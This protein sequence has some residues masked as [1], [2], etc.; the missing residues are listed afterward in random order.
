MNTYVCSKFKD[1]HG[2]DAHQI[3]ERLPLDKREK[4]KVGETLKVSK[5]VSLFIK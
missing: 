5:I 2:K 3:L 4:D 1:M